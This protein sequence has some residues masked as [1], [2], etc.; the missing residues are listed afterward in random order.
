MKPFSTLPAEVH[1]SCLITSPNS[2]GQG[3]C[4][5]AIDHPFAL[6]PL[7]F[8]YVYSHS[9][10]VHYPAGVVQMFHTFKH[11]QG[12]HSVSLI[13]RRDD[14]MHGTLWDTSTSPAS[15]RKHWGNG[16]I[17]LSKHLKGKARRHKL[18]IP[19]PAFPTL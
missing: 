5:A 12:E 4:T 3:K 1:P 10:P 2:C 11:P 9:T 18:P 17:A 14:G 19:A 16:Y 13:T 7:S 6:A 8:G 15:G